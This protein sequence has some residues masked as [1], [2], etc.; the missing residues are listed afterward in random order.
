VLGGENGH[1]QV[2]LVERIDNVAHEMPPFIRRWFLEQ[3][4]AMPS[5]HDQDWDLIL[6]DGDYLPLLI[7]YT[8]EPANRLEKRCV[9]FMAIMVLQ[10]CCSSGGESERKKAIN[11][12]IK[13]IVLG[14]RDFAHELCVGWLGQIETLIVK[15]ILGEAIPSDIPGWMCEEVRSR[16]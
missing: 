1:G 15:N 11:Q 13:R 7:E 2:M 10:E 6:A 9:A 5:L 4:Y 14:N 8:E 12:E 3:D 16:S